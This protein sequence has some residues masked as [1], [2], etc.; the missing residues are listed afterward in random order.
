MAQIAGPQKM[1]RTVQIYGARCP[2][3]SSGVDD[4]EVVREGQDQYGTRQSNSCVKR[5]L[6]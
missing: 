5:L 1:A 2:L 6:N 4:R 3:E